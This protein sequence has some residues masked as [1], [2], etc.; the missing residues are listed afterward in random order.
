VPKQVTPGFEDVMTTFGQT[1]LLVSLHNMVHYGQI[2]D[3]RR[4]AG[5]KPLL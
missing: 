2:T 5:R 1:L 3:A 4:T